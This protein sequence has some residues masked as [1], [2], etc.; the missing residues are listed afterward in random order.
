MDNEGHGQEIQLRNL[1]ANTPL[2]LCNWKNSMV[3]GHVEGLLFRF[4]MSEQIHN[5]VKRYVPNS[6]AEASVACTRRSAFRSDCAR[7]RRWHAESTL[8]RKPAIHATRDRFQNLPDSSAC[9][10]PQFLDLCLLV[11]CDYITASI[12]GLGIATAHRLVDS[13]RS[14]DKVGRSGVAL[15]R[16]VSICLWS[17]STP[18]LM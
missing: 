8:P 1:A 5:P 16:L 7:M 14:L 2:S 12:K 17:N 3:N 13:H 15:N 6:S 10:P 11:G 18:Y 4:L 9:L